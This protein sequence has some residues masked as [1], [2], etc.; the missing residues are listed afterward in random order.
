M[1]DDYERQSLLPITSKELS[2]S[3]K[4]HTE[5]ASDYIPSLTGLRGLAVLLAHY[6]HI[7][8]W[9]SNDRH[10]NGNSAR[11]GVGIF[12]VL[13]GYLIT[14]N[15]LKM[16]ETSRQRGA[17]KYSHLIR[18]Y[19][20]RFVRLY[21]ALLIMVAVMYVT[22]YLVYHGNPPDIKMGWNV[23]IVLSGQSDLFFLFPITWFFYGNTWSLG[24]EEHFYLFWALLLPTISR[25]PFWLKRLVV[26]SM[27]A[28]SL[29]L[30]TASYLRDSQWPFIWFAIQGPLPNFWKMLIGASLR[31]FPTP[32][33]IK[34]PVMGYVGLLIISVS[35]V[36]SFWD[37]VMPLEPVSSLARITPRTSISGEIL[38]EPVMALSSVLMICSCATHGNR[39]F[40]TQ[41]FQLIGR[42]SYSFYLA[43]FPLLML[44]TVDSFYYGLSFTCMAFCYSLISTFYVEEPLRKLYRTYKDT[45]WS[46]KF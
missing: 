5:L 46:N 10:V 2:K 29:G 11:T 3:A 31:L 22:R 25:L 17:G 18:F 19:M 16:Q 45:H 40:E 20:D 33:W 15:L 44:N 6:S 41:F 38:W 9:G 32:A 21:P 4:S 12:F 24:V 39:L 36:T 30:S 23:L 27:I 8:K 13:S 7:G 14:G 34:R 37:P 43:Q 35:I 28:G 1:K 42:V 26:F